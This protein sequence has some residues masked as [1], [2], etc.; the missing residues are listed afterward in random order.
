MKKSIGELVPAL[1]LAVFLSSGPF[2]R[3]QAAGV[4]DPQ[5]KDPTEEFAESLPYVDQVRRQGGYLELGVKDAVRLALSNNLEIAIE[6]Y[7]EQMIRESIT[8]TKGFYDPEL[9]FG[10]GWVSRESPAISI[11]DA[12]RG[13]TTSSSNGLNLTSTISQQVP[14]GGAFEFRFDNRRRSSNSLFSTINPNYWSTSDLSFTQPLWRGFLKT[15]TEH[16]LKLYNLDRRIDDGQFKERVTGIILQVQQQYWELVSAINDHE[17]GRQSR[18]LAILQ[19]RNNKKRVDIGILAPI[20]VSRS[21]TEVSRR[22]KTV[23]QSEV[24]IILYQNALKR[25]LAP[26]PNASMWSLTL[27]PTDRPEVRDVEMT[28]KD[29]IKS[30]FARRPEL[31]RIRLE[32]EKNRVDYDF[33]KREGKPRVNLRANIG[34]VGTSGQTFKNVD[35]LGALTREPDPDH[36]FSG[37]LGNSISQALGF[38]FIDYGVGVE[39]TIPLRNR[40]NE[41]DLARTAIDERRLHSRLQSQQM[42]I[43]EEVR[44]A[45][46]TITTQKKQLEVARMALQLS[47]E[48]LDLETRRFEA[49]LSNNFELLTYQRDLAEAQVQELRA[50]V[51]YQLAVMHLSRAMNTIVSDSDIVLARG[52]NGG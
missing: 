52:Q 17:I 46:E 37:N 22:E 42:L 19:H 10:V 26:D 2:C 20:E 21:R 44:N 9:S 18:E 24:Q 3:G 29:A 38:D 6:D 32:L 30:A 12:G 36:P 23:I 49:G 5:G 25:L 16:Q 8:S 4:A 1:L 48:Q 45:F 40:S 50:Q 13:I 31:E 41:G 7:N 47:G 14:G 33:Y 34:S 28:L 51:D 15:Q 27:I 43:V 39:V 35:F 11:L